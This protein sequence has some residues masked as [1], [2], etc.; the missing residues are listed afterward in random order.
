MNVLVVYFKQQAISCYEKN[1]FAWYYI[2]RL[3][4]LMIIHTG[5]KNFL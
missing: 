2:I 1:R 4:K 3:D 5:I